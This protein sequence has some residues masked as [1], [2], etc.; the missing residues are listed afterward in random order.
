MLGDC[1]E[2][3]LDLEAKG[4][5]Q[6]IPTH[7]PAR[8]RWTSSSSSTCAPPPRAAA[9]ARTADAFAVGV[10]TAFLTPGDDGA[11]RVYERAGFADATVMLHISR[12]AQ[13]EATG[14]R[15]ADDATAE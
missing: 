2:N 6:W 12:P 11:H 14:D 9:T 13:H 8:P 4:H 15:R 3:P 5:H 7:P 10:T 1:P